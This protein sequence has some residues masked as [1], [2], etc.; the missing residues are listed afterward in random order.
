MT[1]KICHHPADNNFIRLNEQTNEF[2]IEK[3]RAKLEYLGYFFP[4]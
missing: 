3:C 1:V 2:T 4:C